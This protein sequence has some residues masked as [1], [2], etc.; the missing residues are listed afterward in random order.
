[1]RL[2][3]LTPEIVGAIDTE[4]G[5]QLDKFGNQDHKRDDAWALILG[6]EY[7]EVCKD[8]LDGRNVRTELVQLAA[9]AIAWIE[10]VDARQEVID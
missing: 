5:R 8:I 3:N 7:G 10:A 6:E 2:Y 9:V 4:R 1:M